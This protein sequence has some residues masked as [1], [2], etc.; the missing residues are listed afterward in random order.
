MAKLTTGKEF[1]GVAGR[2]TEIVHTLEAGDRPDFGATLAMWFL[3]CPMQATAWRHYNLAI[4]HLRPIEG[5]KPAIIRSP[6]ATHEVMLFALN[7]KLNPSPTNAKS[8]QY[9][10]PYNFLGQLKLPSDEEAKRGLEA[11]ARDVANGRLWA[12]PPLSMQR[13]PW[14]TVLRLWEAGAARAPEKVT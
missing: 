5:V 11:M 6:G 8:W 10:S 7:P 12:E 9:L 14:E 4:I 2:A 1:V 3:D 13:E